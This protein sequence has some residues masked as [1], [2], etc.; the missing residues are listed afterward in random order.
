MFPCSWRVRIIICYAG[1]G[2]DDGGSFKEFVSIK[3]ELAVLQDENTKL[4]EKISVSAVPKR[5]VSGVKR[6]SNPNI[7][8]KFVNDSGDW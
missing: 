4:K 2:G 1:R 5:A 3:R 8:L 6:G 7:S